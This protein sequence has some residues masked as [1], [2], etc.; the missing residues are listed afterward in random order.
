VGR[1]TSVLAK[2]VGHVHAYDIS[3]PHL[4]IAAARVAGTCSGNVD[5]IRVKPDEKI[6]FRACD[7][8]YSR[9]VLQH[10]T[11]P[12]ILATLEAAFSAIRPGGVALFQVPVYYRDYRFEIGDYIRNERLDD[13]EMNC[14]PQSEIFRLAKDHGMDVILVREDGSTGSPEVFVSNFFLLRKAAA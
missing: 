6:D 4:D 13:M 12:I 14:V 8:L 2:H 5:F 7:L 1:V 9:I 11:P 3:Q 10:N